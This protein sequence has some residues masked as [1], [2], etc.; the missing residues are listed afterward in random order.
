MNRVCNI[1]HIADIVSAIMPEIVLFP[2]LNL[3]L[4]AVKL[5]P[6]AKYLKIETTYQNRRCFCLSE[7]IVLLFIVN[8]CNNTTKI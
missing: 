3:K 6:V 4:N 5:L 1:V 2:F 7:M 8:V